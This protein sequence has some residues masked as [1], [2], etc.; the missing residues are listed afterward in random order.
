MNIRTYSLYGYFQRAMSNNSQFTIYLELVSQS[1]EK[2]SIELCLSQ[3]LNSHISY[4]YKTVLIHLP[5]GQL[6]LTP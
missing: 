6:I 5:T 3:S 1:L 2:S 4:T